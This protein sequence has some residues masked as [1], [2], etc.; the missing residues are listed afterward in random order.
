MGQ[1]SNRI[2]HP[3]GDRPNVF[4]DVRLEQILDDINEEITGA[5]FCEVTRTGVFIDKVTLWDAPAKNK[6][7]SESVFT[8]SGPFITQVVRDIFNDIDGTVGVARTTTTVS[9]DGSNRITDVESVDV[10]LP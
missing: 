6:K 2:S 8:R 10:R 9:R 1:D 4:R 7:R 3:I 5:G